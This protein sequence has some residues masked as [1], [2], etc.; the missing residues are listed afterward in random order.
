MPRMLS[1]LIYHPGI[2]H[3]NASLCLSIMFAYAPCETAPPNCEESEI[4]TK[5][6]LPVSH[7][8]PHFSFDATFPVSMPSIPPSRWS[9][10][11]LLNHAYAARFANNSALGLVSCDR[12]YLT[13]LRAFPSLSRSRSIGVCVLLCKTRKRSACFRI[14]ACDARP[15]CAFEPMAAS[16]GWCGRRQIRHQRGAFSHWIDCALAQ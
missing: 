4:D 16:C 1:C 5:P 2:A 9:L 13:L 8:R 12:H 6:S 3:A 11:V 15:I 14:L 10:V 7:W